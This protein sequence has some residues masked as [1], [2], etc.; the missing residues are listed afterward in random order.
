MYQ[1]NMTLEQIDFLQV[2][3]ITLWI[4]LDGN[5]YVVDYHSMHT[6]ESTKLSSEMFKIV[7]WIEASLSTTLTLW[8]SN[9]VHLLPQRCSSQVGARVS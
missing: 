3:W 1:N 7:S 9:G 4:L 6:L 5:E 2:Y 8:T